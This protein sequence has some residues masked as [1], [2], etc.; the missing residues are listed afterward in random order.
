[1]AVVPSKEVVGSRNDA[2]HLPNA[3]GLYEGLGVEGVALGVWREGT[4][5]RRPRIPKRRED[6][7]GEDTAT[8]CEICDGILWGVRDARVPRPLTTTGACAARVICV[9]RRQGG[10]TAAVGRG[11]GLLYEITFCWEPAFIFDPWLTV[12]DR[13][14][15]ASA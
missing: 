14:K 10:V 2:R 5:A 12:P 9:G 3:R 11:G 15:T 7:R 1:M 13:A 4:G 6:D 8:T